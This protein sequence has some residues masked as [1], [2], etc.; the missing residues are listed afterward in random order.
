MKYRIGDLIQYKGVKYIILHTVR[1]KDETCGD[2]VDAY[3]YTIANQH[4]SPGFV[5]AASAVDA[6]YERV[7]L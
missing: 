1:M 4:N 5:R 6:K 2:W 7:K 3:F